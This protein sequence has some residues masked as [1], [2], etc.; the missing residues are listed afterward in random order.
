MIYA[1]SDLHGCYTQ[2]LEMLKK[3]PFSDND[4]LYILG[5]LIDRGPDGIKIIQDVM[6]RNNV[7]PIIGNHELF[8][9]Y[10]SGYSTNSATWYDGWIQDGGAPT[11]DAFQKLT[12]QEQL[13][14]ILYI[15][16]MPLYREVNAGGNTFFL[17]H[18]LP[19]KNQMHQFIHQPE[20]RFIIGEPEYDK[21][22]FNDKY[23]VT[24]HIPTGLISKEFI[25]KIWTGNHH[26]AIDC[27]AVFGNPLG[28][29]CLDTL[30][31]FYVT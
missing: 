19:K 29:V 5:D 12:A 31:E 18:T 30:E 21:V 3:I 25:G 27:G 4:V 24:G 23:T 6:K 7:I 14:V 17:S 26:I 1:M 2:Y 22:Y 28:C 16:R 10:A 13:N 15:S 20:V 11:Y 8:A 9:L